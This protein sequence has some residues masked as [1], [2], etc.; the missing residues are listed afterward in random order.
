MKLF[1]VLFALL[2]T[3]LV[4][5]VVAVAQQVVELPKVSIVDWTQLIPVALSFVLPLILGAVK[6]LI[7]IETTT[8]EGIVV[9]TLPK[10]FPKW[11]PLVLAPVLILAADMLTQLATG[12]PGINPYLLVTVFPAITAWI[13]NIAEQIRKAGTG[14]S[15]QVVMR[16]AA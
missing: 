5:P 11:L 6:K 16:K 12:N 13:Y 4:L 7:I 3:L 15:T 1:K 8:P 2:L 10:W 14:Q 9:Y